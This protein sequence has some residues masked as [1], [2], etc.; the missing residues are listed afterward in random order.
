[1]APDQ[2]DQDDGQHGG[3]QDHVEPVEAGQHV[4]QRAV[5]AR[6]EL[7]VQLRVRVVVFG[8]LTGHEDEA[9]DDRGGQPEHRLAAVVLAQRMVGDGQR[10]ARGQQQRGVDGGQPERAH[11]LELFDHAGRTEVG[12]GGLEVGPQHQAVI[13]VAQPRRGDRARVP[14]R[15]EERGE[16]HHFREDEPAHAPTVRTVDTLAVHAGFGFLDGVA[17]PVLTPLIQAAA[18][19]PMN[20]SATAVRT[21]CPESAGTK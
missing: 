14:E 15:A 20:S 8:G 11:R 12:P 5:R 16:E 1:M 9:Q 10:D 21:G 2:A 17:E 13:D 7:Q 4:E 3:A 19:S 6:V 18:P